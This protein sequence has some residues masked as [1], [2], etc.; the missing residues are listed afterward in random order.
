MP[1]VM[2][3]STYL[4]DNRRQSRLINTHVDPSGVDSHF[5]SFQRDDH[6][7]ISDEVRL[8]AVQS[9]LHF[10][11]DTCVTETE[12]SGTI[13]ATSTLREAQ[14]PFNELMLTEREGRGPCRLRVQ[15]N[16]VGRDALV[17]IQQ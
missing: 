8:R 11:L 15:G 16:P 9:D 3:V 5:P 17:Q 7:V 4:Q 10:V 14:Q 6:L 12:M 13:A 1:S 2:R